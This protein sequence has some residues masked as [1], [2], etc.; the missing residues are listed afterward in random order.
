MLTDSKIFTNPIKS[1]LLENNERSF[2][3]IIEPLA[4][5]YGYTLGNS[6]RRI[7]L[8]SI[9][10]CAITKIRIKGISHEYQPIPGVV[11]DAMDV[12]LNLK[13]L[14]CKILNSEDKVNITLSKSEGGKVLAQDFK[15]EGKVEISNPDM[16]ICS[17][18]DKSSF[19]V[20]VEISKGAGYLSMEEINLSSTLDPEEI[21][22]DAVF[23]PVTSVLLNVEKVRVGDKTNFDKL[24]VRFE[25]DGSISGKEVVDFSL[26]LILDLFS[27][28]KSSFESSQ[29]VKDLPRNVKSV[30]KEVVKTSLDEIDLPPRI[31]NILEKNGIVTNQD[32][33][34]K[35]EDIKDFAGI[36]EKTI[37]KIQEYINLL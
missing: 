22:V 15:T 11:E 27:R 33:K 29:D 12:V 36:S 7:L 32:L 4:P 28:I 13:Q 17:L 8:S 34:E 3:L 2:S 5:G 25:T 18:N 26:N 10:G 21:L 31:K 30:E 1:S 6:L 35:I 14:R 23:T 19:E 24:E 20:E 37:E 9:P 16:Y